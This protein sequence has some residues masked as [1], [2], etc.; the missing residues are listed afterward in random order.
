MTLSWH[1][2]PSTN[3]TILQGMGDQHIDVAIRKAEVKVPDRPAHCR[4]TRA[5]PG[6]DHQG[7]QAMYRHKKQTGGAGQFGE[8]WM[9]IEPLHEAEYEFSWDVF[10]GAVSVQLPARN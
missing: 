10:G 3:Q 2:E 1:Q 5:I 8:V 9:R 6:I 4:A 7:G